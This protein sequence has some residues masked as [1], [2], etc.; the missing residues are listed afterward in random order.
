MHA[1]T[2]I[3]PVAQKVSIQE[4]TGVARGKQ[5]LLCSST[6]YFDIFNGPASNHLAVVHSHV[7]DRWI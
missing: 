1:V 3:G 4:A 7:V 2:G 6:S 5:G